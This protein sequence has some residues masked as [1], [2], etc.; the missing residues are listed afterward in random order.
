M[1]RRPERILLLSGWCPLYSEKWG[2]LAV[3]KMLP[4]LG[5]S[6]V[7]NALACGR[8]D[9]NINLL[10]SYCGFCRMRAVPVSSFGGVEAAG[11]E[12]MNGSLRGPPGWYA[13]KCSSRSLLKLL[14]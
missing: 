6:R 2:A 11:R 9:T 8:A 7:V 1:L 14:A 3:V 12:F 10:D 13:W 4:H 5:A